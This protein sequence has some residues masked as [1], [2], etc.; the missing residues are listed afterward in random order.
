L[1]RDPENAQVVAPHIDGI[2][3]VL[4]Q[5]FDEGM[6][7]ELQSL[8][9]AV[10][11]ML[12]TL[13][14]F[15]DRIA[16]GTLAFES[17]LRAENHRA[18]SLAS[19]VLSS[20]HAA[21]AEIDRAREALALGRLAAETSADPGEH[22]R[23]MRA[24]GVV[25]YKAGDAAGALAAIDGAEAIARDT[26]EREILVN[27]LGLRTVACWHLGRFSEAK[28]AA[29][30]GLQACR[31]MSW[32]RATAYPLR[33]LAEVAL[34]E[35]DFSAAADLLREARTVASESADRRQLARISL[36]AARMM[37]LA[38]ES[39]TAQ[40]EAR[41]ALEQARALGLPPE[42]QEARALVAASTRARWL[43]PLRLYYRSRRPARLTAAA[44]GGD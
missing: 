26:G 29:E 20:T 44:V 38:G 11:D 21:R 22:A 13:G 1:A 6:D 8:F 43:A 9:V 34:H 39:G 42:Q 31:E 17:A 15:D 23:Q 2:K 16:T 25:S 36:T 10:L 28:V 18:A 14:L 33:N 41:G 5:L 40:I 19:D 37:L 4:Q 3:A 32:R 7:A 27:V 12:F 35:G 24:A 30:A